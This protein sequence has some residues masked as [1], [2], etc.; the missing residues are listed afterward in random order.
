[1]AEYL[2]IICKYTCPEMLEAT[3][4]PAVKYQQTK[5]KVAHMIRYGISETA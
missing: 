5:Y 1:M 4:K 3:G 2:H